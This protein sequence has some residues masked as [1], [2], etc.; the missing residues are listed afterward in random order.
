MFKIDQ[1]E[2]YANLDDNYSLP[3]FTCPKIIAGQNQTNH[4]VDN[5]RIVI[6]VYQNGD[7]QNRINQMLA[8]LWSQIAAESFRHLVIIVMVVASINLTKH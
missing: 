6:L 3:T 8:N 4:V 1:S 7:D 2:F 5:N